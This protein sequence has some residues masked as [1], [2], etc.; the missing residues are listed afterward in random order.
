M[1]SGYIVSAIAWITYGT[2]HNL[3]LF[4]V[5]SVIEGFAIAWSY[6]AKAAFLVQVVPERWLGSVQG[7]ETTFVQIAGLTGTLVAPLIYAHVSGYVIAVA[8]G[9]SIV[10]LLLAGPILFK[11]WGRLQRERD[12][13]AGI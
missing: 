7:L 4:L 3:T 1:F 12:R 13:G 8:G 6:P 11:E 2:A 10:G 5:V 9:I